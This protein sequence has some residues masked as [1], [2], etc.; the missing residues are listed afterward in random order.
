MDK[1]G[2]AQANLQQNN[3]YYQFY[4]QIVQRGAQIIQQL[5]DGASNVVDIDGSVMQG[6]QQIAVSLARSA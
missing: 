1:M 2:P 3:M 5:S 6:Y 4:Q